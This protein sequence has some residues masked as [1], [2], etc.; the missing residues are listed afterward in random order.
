MPARP[1]S[2][3]EP[4]R[5]NEFL[6]RYIEPSD[7]LSPSRARAGRAAVGGER[8]RPGS[9]PLTIASEI[10]AA[11]QAPPSTTQSCPMPSAELRRRIWKVAGSPG[12]SGSR[13]C[14]L[15]PAP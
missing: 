15:P 7:L 12:A 1:H 3:I 11:T 4:G 2:D 9:H 14:L 13:V 8:E 5:Q 10:G 6:H